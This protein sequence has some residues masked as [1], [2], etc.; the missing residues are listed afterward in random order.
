MREG[1]WHK[2]NLPRENLLVPV[3]GSWEGEGECKE[4]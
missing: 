4:C 1:R 3:R 2:N